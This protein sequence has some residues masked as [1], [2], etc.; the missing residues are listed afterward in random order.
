MLYTSISIREIS[1][2]EFIN[3]EDIEREWNKRDVFGE[4][5]AEHFEVS[6]QIFT[7]PKTRGSSQKYEFLRS[8]ACFRFHR[9][10]IPGHL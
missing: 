7:L 2:F 1:T 9:R 4:R 10:H 5:L 6:R 8:K 3:Y